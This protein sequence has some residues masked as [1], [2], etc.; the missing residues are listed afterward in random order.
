MA[1][2]HEVRAA[3]TGPGIS[4]KAATC[5]WNA[6]RKYLRRTI[7]KP[8]RLRTGPHNQ[9]SITAAENLG[10]GWAEAPGPNPEPVYFR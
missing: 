10:N 2:A 8:G 9:Y 7:T 3:L 6:S 4:P 5:K 1:A